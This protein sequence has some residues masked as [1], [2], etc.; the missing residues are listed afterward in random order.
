MIIVTI[1]LDSHLVDLLALIQERLDQ[2][3]VSSPSCFA[4]ASLGTGHLVVR[5]VKLMVVAMVKVMM[6]VVNVHWSY[7]IMKMFDL[8]NL[9]YLAK[10]QIAL[11]A[12]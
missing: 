10:L 7:G 4:E 11:F 8:E 9:D 6:K 3:K 2:P 12:L 5:V 1:M